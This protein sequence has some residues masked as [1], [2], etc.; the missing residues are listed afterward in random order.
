MRFKKG[1]YVR[2]WSGSGV[3]YGQI[4]DVRKDG[5]C[6]VRIG[7]TDWT[8]T[9]EESK[10]ALHPALVASGMLLGEWI[11]YRKNPRSD[12]YM[13]HVGAYE[14]LKSIISQ[15]GLRPRSQIDWSKLG[16]D[17]YTGADV[18][19]SR[20][21]DVNVN[22]QAY[23]E[24]PKSGAYCLGDIGEFFYAGTNTDTAWGYLQEVAKSKRTAIVFRFKPPKHVVWYQ[25][26]R[27]GG[28]MTM[29]RIP[30]TACEVHLVS[31]SKLKKAVLGQDFTVEEEI[32]CEVG[33]DGEHWISCGSSGWDSTLSL[34]YRFDQLML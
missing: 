3:V 16:G 4:D 9:I 28:L 19:D 26:P 12:R 33:T 15:K 1:Q 2:Y 5:K 24:E 23:L 13:Y 30:L 29:G 21:K 7:G 18:S 10:L 32:M 6:S 8:R 20:V 22:L 14:N 31:S 27:S 17:V 25:D 34:S 11:L